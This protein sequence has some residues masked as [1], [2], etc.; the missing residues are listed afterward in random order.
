MELAKVFVKVRGDSSQL[1][2]DLNA[3]KGP[4]TSAAKNIASSISKI[5][6]GI[7]AAF[8]ISRFVALAKESVGLAKIQID[9][10][11]KLSGA[12][13][14]NGRSID[15]LMPRYKAFAS[16]MQ[17][18]TVV[19]DETTL[20][21]LQVAE[22]MGL[23]G[24]AAE[25]VAKNSIAMQA[26][27]GMNA[28]SAAR[29]A[30]ALQQGDAVM[31]TRYIPE[32]KSIKDNSEKVAR[33]Q[34]IL[35]NAFQVA[36]EQ[37]KSDAGQNEQ[38]KNKLG[39]LKE[40]MGR[41]LL[42][43]FN[44]FLK[45]QIQLQRAINSVVVAVVA[46]DQAFGGLPSKLLLA[47][48]ATTALVFAMKALRASGLVGFVGQSVAQLG[49]FVKSLFTTRIAVV[50]LGRGI[51]IAL[52]TS[53]VG[54]LVVVIGLAVFALMKFVKMV[55]NAI[56]GHKK[57]PAVIAKF[58]EAWERVKMAFVEIG[59]AI[60]KVIRSIAEAL[61]VDFESAADDV[62]GFIIEMFDKVANFVV[63]AAKLFQLFVKE[64]GKAWEIIVQAAKVAMLKM[65]DFIHG[66]LKLWLKLFKEQF[67]I[68]ASAVAAGFDALLAGENP[69]EA[70]WDDSIKAL[71]KIIADTDFEI[72]PNTTAA[73]ADLK[74]L[75]DGV[76]DGL[77]DPDG[78]LDG[79]K[80]GAD[81][82][83][84]KIGEAKK[85]LL[86]A[87]PRGR[88]GFSDLGRKAQDLLLGGDGGAEGRDKKKV[89]F[90]EAADG[91]LGD[92]DDKLGAILD[93]GPAGAV[94]TA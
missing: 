11:Q 13:M 47:V 19:G 10:E 50:A 88:I 70:M 81:A 25:Q 41:A 30:A 80:K 94:L 74:K 85:G 67:A 48:A 79:M 66:A 83:A 72:H 16:Q 39:D 84:D 6:A 42:P 2:K 31:L 62:A 22:S 14:A 93:R 87:L 4:A 60:M 7:G 43:V 76:F 89:K 59:K 69:F 29:Y 54:I 36:T 20:G 46:F 32:L 26:A 8:T 77:E 44:A 75:M 40:T 82:V 3:A 49:V 45:V 1:P 56:K 55:H 18:I 92:I 65:G 5:F 28:R 63:R 61:G 24:D 78:L 58:R 53:G 17:D 35:A 73:E 91:K 52:I 68:I 57:F 33:A 38:L 27:F 51:K 12:I 86:A 90:A 71:K 37:A 34:E 64:P 21:I 15:E 23:T 9:A